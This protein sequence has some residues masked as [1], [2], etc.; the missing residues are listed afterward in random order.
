MGPLRAP[1]YNSVSYR[2]AFQEKQH[3]VKEA[4]LFFQIGQND[5]LGYLFLKVNNVAQLPSSG[6]LRT[7]PCGDFK[8]T[9]GFSVWWLSVQTFGL[10]GIP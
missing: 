6:R 7:S 9:S 4:D 2:A 3:S 10:A 5:G 8:V 1:L